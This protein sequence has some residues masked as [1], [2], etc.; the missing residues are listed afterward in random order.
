MQER[1]SF[2][3]PNPQM[4]LVLKHF[5]EE[6]PEVVD[7]A[8]Q[9]FFA[10]VQ[11]MQERVEQKKIEALF[12]EWFVYDFHLKTGKTPLE[13]YVYRNPDGLDEG[14]LDLLQQ[15]GDSN[16]TSHFWVGKVD[17]GMHSLELRECSDG[18]IFEVLDVTAS[19]SVASNAGIVAARLIKL[20]DKWFFASDPIYF[21]P[22]P[23]LSESGK[24]QNFSDV[25]KLHYGM[26]NIPPAEEN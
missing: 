12:N 17:P 8:G 15:A 25:V 11:A 6:H 16:Y 20:D 5:Y 24:G 10:H 21:M 13:T 19:Q 1:Q 18:E 3:Y 22:F 26:W 4:S 23:P 2:E 14:E 9:E 7:R